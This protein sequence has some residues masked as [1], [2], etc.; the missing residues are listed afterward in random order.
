MRLREQ[1]AAHPRR[2]WSLTQRRRGRCREHRLSQAFHRSR[3]WHR[4]HRTK[5]HNP[6]TPM[7]VILNATATPT[8]PAQH[9]HPEPGK[10]IF[11]NPDK[12]DHGSGVWTDGEGVRGGYGG[13]YGD[14]HEAY[15]AYSLD[16]QP[17]TVA[18][19]GINFTMLAKDEALRQVR[20]CE[21]IIHD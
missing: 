11:F 19:T 4:T 3:A 7:P 21:F 12:K 1:A 13:G 16:D 5:P 17:K 6:A 2:R 9:Q 10:I 8:A 15:A 18:I 14:V 20:S